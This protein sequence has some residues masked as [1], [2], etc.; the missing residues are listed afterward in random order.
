[1]LP[2]VLMLLVVAIGVAVPLRNDRG[3]YYWDDTAAAAVGVW[4]RI[5]DQVLSGT[6]PILQ[7]DMWRGGNF[8]AEAATGMFNPVMVALMVAIHPLDNLAIGITLAKGVLFALVAL[9]VY[10]L[11]REYGATRWP[12]AIVGA[13]MA[14]SGYTVFMDGTSWV[15]GLAI[16]AFTPWLWWAARR[17][18]EGRGSIWVALVAGYLLVSTGN[19]YGV[20]AFAAVMG[21]LGVETLVRRRPRKLWWL[22]G[23]IVVAALTAVIVYLPF[24][25][26]STVGSRAG[27]VTGNDEFFAPGLSDLLGMSSPTFQPYITMFGGNPMS[28]PGL[29]LAWFLLPLIPWLRWRSLVARWPAWSGAAAF[30]V[31]YLL[32]VLGPS[33]I[34]MFRWPARL[35]PFLA[36]AIFV[37]FAVALTAGLARDRV[38]LRAW[39]TTAIVLLGAWQTFSDRPNQ[40]VWAV[41]GLIGVAALMYAFLKVRSGAQWFAVVAVGAIGVLL[42]QTHWMP[43]NR[44][45]ADYQ[46]PQSRSEIQESFAGRYEGMTV[47]VANRTLPNELETGDGAWRDILFGNLY[48]VSGVES[49]TAYSGIGFTKHDNALCLTYFGGT[50]P[51]A[52]DALWENPEGEDEQLAD[53]LRVETVVVL[54]NIV[55]DPVAPEGW[56]QVDETDFVRVFH[57]DEPIPFPDGRL[58]I[59]GDAVDVSSDVSTGDRAERVVVSTG[60]GTAQD[61]SLTFSRLAWPGY[62]VTVDG[63]P[64]EPITGPAGLLRVELPAGL[65]DAEVEI[66]FLPPGWTAGVAALGLAAAIAVGLVVVDGVQRRRSRRS[67]RGATTEDAT[68]DQPAPDASLR[69]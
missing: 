28:F 56:T 35:L 51:G 53:L 59:A 1:M 50:C 54:L 30:G 44:S 11:A 38:R 61:R 10:L 7:L 24:L 66:S 9:G 15:N 16:T 20:L 48:S 63:T 34:W 5:A 45:V 22:G 27:S 31:F 65:T 6:F 46:F 21:A 26:T 42:V 8:V 67:V 41:A 52:W 25:L 68:L 49:T 32:L 40:Y 69:G 62:T 17:H 58:S 57:R 33:Q 2:P 18:L 47:Q 4:Q 19:P 13:S 23:Q 14:L 43:V 39:L 36:I 55:P 3:F 64:V 37:I 60:D 12:A 29:Y